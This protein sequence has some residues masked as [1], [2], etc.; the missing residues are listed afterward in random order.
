MQP[1]HL[2]DGAWIGRPPQDGIALVE[3]G[4]NAGAIRF[5][6]PPRSQVSADRHQA[7]LIGELGIEENGHE[8]ASTPLAA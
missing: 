1:I 2:E 4:K 7:H 5:H 8:D 3:P 6:E